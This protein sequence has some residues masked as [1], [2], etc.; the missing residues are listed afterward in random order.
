MHFA[1]RRKWFEATGRISPWQQSDTYVTSVAKHAG[2]WNPEW[3][4]SVG[5]VDPGAGPSDRL[6]DAVT[7][8]IRYC[9]N[10]PEHEARRDAQIIRSLP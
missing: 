8:E 7:A 10:L 4:F 9:A 5:H 6:P 2:V 1:I 3:V